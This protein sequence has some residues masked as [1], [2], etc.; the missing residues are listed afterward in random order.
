MNAGPRVAR[1][2][3]EC[4]YTPPSESRCFGPVVATADWSTTRRCARLAMSGERRHLV[5]RPCFAVA[6]GGSDFRSWLRAAAGRECPAG[7]G[8]REETGGGQLSGL[9]LMLATR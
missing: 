8:S 2:A 3:C 6:E 4:A 1:V 9:Q 7:C 5:A